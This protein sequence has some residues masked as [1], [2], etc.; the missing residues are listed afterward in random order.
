MTELYSPPA[1]WEGVLPDTLAESQER[2]LPVGATRGTIVPSAAPPPESVFEPLRD[3]YGWRL[4]LVFGNHAPS[5]H[6]PYYALKRCFHCDIGAGEGAAFDHKS[7]RQR[8]EWFRQYYK[9]QLATFRH[10][11]IYNSGSVLNPR[12]LAPEMLREIVAFARSLPSIR[13]ISLD[14]RETY[15][16]Q[17]TLRPILSVLGSGIMVRPILGLE[18]ADER[19]RNEV[20]RKEM[21]RA[22]IA[23]AF[24]TVGFLAAEFGNN[25]IGLDVNIVLAGPGTSNATAV[26]DAVRTAHFALNCG[27]EHGVSV[28][29][30]L[31]PYYAGTRGSARFP[32]HPRCSLPT[33]LRAASQIVAVARSL[34]TGSSLFIGWHDE[35]HDLEQEQRRR[36]LEQARAALDRF[37]ET[38]DPGELDGL[39]LRFVN[40]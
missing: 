36:E 35:G 37:N 1:C 23:R 34:G 3:R 28:D 29:L 32:G 7:N 27:I 2:N 31:H 26:D 33:V 39:E 24:Q 13:V 12:E 6:C 15:I 4:A 21:P 10:L 8:L 30:N 9:R 18:S 38:N 25:R 5:G 20:L 16:R 19:V 14:T 22:A 17:N 40:G 11:V